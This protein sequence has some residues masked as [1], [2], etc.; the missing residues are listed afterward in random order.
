MNSI[1]VIILRTLF[2]YFFIFLIYRI[3]G[4]REIGQLSIID[5]VVSILIAEL[6]AISIEN[7][8]ETLLYTVIPITILVVLEILLSYICMKSNKIRTLIEGKPS[9]IINKGIINYKEMKHQRYTLD[10]LLLELRKKEYVSI[11]DIDYAIL[12]TDGSLSLFKK[13]SKSVLP[14][15]V[16]LDGSIIK[17]SLKILNIN[18][19]YLLECLKDKNTC[20]K[21]VFYAFF[22]NSELYIIK[23]DEINN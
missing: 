1:Y 13:N 21:N 22:E 18:K 6:V 23:K 9:L 14:Y 17:E 15:P 4:K 10:D 8:K 16:I 3:M 19:S 20:L 12:E 11:K 5:L 2:F 7:H